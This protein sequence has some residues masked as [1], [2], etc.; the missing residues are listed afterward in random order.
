MKLKMAQNSVFAILL[1]SSWWISAAI[2][3]ALVVLS[4]A[5][6][7]PL[8]STFFLFAAIPFV[9]ISGVSGWRQR[10]RPSAARVE[11]TIATVR[12]MSWPAFG[13][14]LHESFRL[15]GCAIERLN[16]E[17]ADFELRRKNRMAIVSARRWKASRVGVQAL[18]GLNAARLARGAQEAIYVTTGE[19]SE[20]AATYARE[21][22][23]Q[24]LAGQQLVQLLPRHAV[25]VR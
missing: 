8:F 25:P 20:Q 14:L 5:I 3:V 10:N 11:Q 21:N 15:D 1:R 24:F 23:I 16:G 6:A 7:Q 13:A 22:D 4:Q 2:A 19:I 18:Q 12:E 17:H 9:V